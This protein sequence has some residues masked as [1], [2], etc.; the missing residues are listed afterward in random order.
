VNLWKLVG[1]LFVLA[2]FA[3]TVWCLLTWPTPT[4]VAIAILGALVI[5]SVRRDY[6]R[7]R[8]PSPFG[9]VAQRPRAVVDDHHLCWGPIERSLGDT[10]KCPECR[11]LW[12]CVEH[13]QG[14]TIWALINGDNRCPNCVAP[15]EDTDAVRAR[16]GIVWHERCARQLEAVGIWP[17]QNGGN[18]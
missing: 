3:G 17:K 6:L 11:R 18:L 12:H 7:A 9:G 13:H 10:W 8:R 2:T 1:L 16:G 15:I 5:A 14:G 4:A